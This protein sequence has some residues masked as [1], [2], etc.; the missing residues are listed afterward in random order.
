MSKVGFFLSFDLMFSRIKTVRE[1]FDH[2]VSKLS[3]IY[4]RPEAQSMARIVFHEVLGYDTIKRIKAENE[5]LPAALFEQLDLILDQLLQHKPV[6]YV[7]GQTYFCGLA[8]KVNE[9]VLIPRPETEE[10][11]DWVIQTL[12]ENE[13]DKV[14]RIVDIGTGSGCIPLAIKYN[15]SNSDVYGF[16]ISAEAI[17]VAESNAKRLG[18]SVYFDQIDILHDSL[19]SNY[20][21]MISNPPYVKFSEKMHMRKNV[22][23]YEPHIALFVFDEDP[24]IFYKRIATLAMEYLNKDGLL[25][26]EINEEYGKE[27]VALLTNKGF[28]KIELR[29]DFLRKNRFIRCQ[30]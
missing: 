20:D 5:L 2:F 12:K 28:R 24:L 23:D 26:F 9:S 21:V 1:A 4:E 8:F 10:L 11:V 27:I 19:N 16:D 30:K 15:I 25:F 18:L 6:Q 29:A 3:Q 22:L 17:A 7:L 14:R 13:N